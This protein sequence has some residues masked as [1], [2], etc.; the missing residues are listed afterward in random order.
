MDI[1]TGKENE[2][3]KMNNKDT[4]RDIIMVI[5]ALLAGGVLRLLIG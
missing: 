5:S 4:I 2:M 1:G 3:K